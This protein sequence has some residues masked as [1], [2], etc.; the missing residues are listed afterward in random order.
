M[1][2]IDFRI[3][4]PVVPGWRLPLGVFI[5]GRPLTDIVSATEV[6]F[7]DP[8]AGGDGYYWL[9]ARYVL[10]PSRHLWGEP[11]QACGWPVRDVALLG[12][13]CGIPD[14]WSFTARVVVGQGRVGW[15]G[16]RQYRRE[17]WRY[18]ALGGFVFDAGQYDSALAS[19]AE[20]YAAAS[21]AEP[22]D[23]ADGG[24]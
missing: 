19:A 20:A 14:C 1:N 22:G 15:L 23:A 13:R 24:A 10:P 7:G 3:L 18:D 16:F 11:F 4:T 12:C 6:A 21:D 17:W 5:D 9:P 8:A 2:R